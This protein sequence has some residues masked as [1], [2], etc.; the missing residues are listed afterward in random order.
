MKKRT[1]RNVQLD[2]D[3]VKELKDDSELP[4]PKSMNIIQIKV[5]NERI[6]C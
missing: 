6:S 5:K 1:H 4:L 2:K 3:F